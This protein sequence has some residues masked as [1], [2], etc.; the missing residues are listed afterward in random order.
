MHQQQEFTSLITKH[1]KIIY[2]VCNLY[3]EDKTDRQDLFQ[4]I[5]LQAWKS[6]HL[7]RGDA[8]F[9]TWLYRI[10]LN[11]AITFFKKEKKQV[12]AIYN[13]VLPELRNVEDEREEQFKAMYTAIGNLNKIDKALV[14]LYLEDYSYIE[15][16][17]TLGITPNN[18]AVKMNRLKLKL[19]EEAE[20][21]FKQ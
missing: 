1:Q 13:E 11:T 9:S 16:S 8:Q 2:K 20:K 3:V 17:E 6:Y 5:C 12:Q 10:A 18:V 14:M 7:F 21:N 15:I 4:E 19:K